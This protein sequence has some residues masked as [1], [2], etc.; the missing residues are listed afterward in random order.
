MRGR[1]Y[2]LLVMSQRLCC[3]FMEHIVPITSSKD[4]SWSTSLVL[5]VVLCFS[6]RD[7][8]GFGMLRHGSHDFLDRRQ[9]HSD[10]TVDSN[11]DEQ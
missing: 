3:I 1:C 11:N 6:G 10:G 7:A 9:C 4:R 8:V 5:M 2:L